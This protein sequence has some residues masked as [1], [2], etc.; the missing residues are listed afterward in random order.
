M[1]ESGIQIKS[2]NN[3]NVTKEIFSILFL[4]NIFLKIQEM[5]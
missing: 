1:M 4:Q 2:Y 5:Q 3:R